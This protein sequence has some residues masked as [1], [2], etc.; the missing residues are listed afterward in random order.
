MIG[1]EARR[2]ETVLYSADCE[3]TFTVYEDI[4][5]GVVCKFYLSREPLT[6]NRNNS[7][8]NEK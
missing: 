5:K 4:S 7:A 8:Q 1:K 2:K 6:F 3:K